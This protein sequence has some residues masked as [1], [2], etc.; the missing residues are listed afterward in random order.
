MTTNKKIAWIEDDIGI[1]E[2]VIQPLIADGYKFTYL[3]NSKEVLGKIDFLKTV[4]LILLDLIFPSGDEAI[5]FNQY[6]GVNLLERLKNE[7]GVETPVIVLTVVTN[8]QAHKQLRE[9]GVIEIINKPVRP[10]EL[11][12]AVNQALTG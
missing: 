7:F 3:R 2:D 10:S 6:P 1:I 12:E 4:D 8:G 5:D 9:L 11:R